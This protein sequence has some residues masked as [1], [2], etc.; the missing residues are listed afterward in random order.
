MSRTT[1]ILLRILLGVVIIGVLVAAGVL[2]YRAGYGV[3]YRA[4]SSGGEDGALGWPFFG[5][6]RGNLPDTEDGTA[7]NYPLRM[8]HFM[9]NRSNFFSPFACLLG[10]GLIVALFALLIRPRYWSGYPHHWGPPPWV[11]PPGGA[12]QPS[13]PSAG[14]ESPTGTEQ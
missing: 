2:I 5:F 3:G 14:Q 9:R 13:Q 11:T 7:P 6:W 12:G 8:L 10:I 1:S 4:G